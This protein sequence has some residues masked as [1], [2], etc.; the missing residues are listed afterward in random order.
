MSRAYN[1]S[2]LEE[3]AGRLVKGYTQE[4]IHTC[5]CKHTHRSS[6]GSSECPPSEGFS[7]D[8]LGEEVGPLSL[9]QGQ[10][11]EAG[12][13]VAPFHSQALASRMEEGSYPSTISFLLL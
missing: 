13:G 5:T 9:A 10:G 6:P 12:F 4:H 1:L 7:Q 2:S 8:L 3:E 11:E